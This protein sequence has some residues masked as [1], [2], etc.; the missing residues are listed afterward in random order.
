MNIYP[1]TPTPP[2]NIFES[3]NDILGILTKMKIP[4]RGQKNKNCI[5]IR[6][7]DSIWE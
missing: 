6:N 3:R 2:K 4:W 7:L 1:Y 5:S